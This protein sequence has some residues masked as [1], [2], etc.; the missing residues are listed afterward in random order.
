MKSASTS[1]RKSQKLSD[2]GEDQIISAITRSLSSGE[3]VIVGP[4]DD[5]A[6]VDGGNPREWTL[7]KTDAV[8]ESV[9]FLPGEDPRRVGWKALCRAISDIGAMGGRPDFCLITLSASPETEMAS[10]LALYTGLRKAAKQFGV[11]IVGGELA[12]S[13][14][15]LFCSIALTGSVSRSRCVLR[16]GGRPGDLLYVT[17]RLGGSYHSG[18]HLDFTPRVVEGQW[19]AGEFPLHA[20]MDLSDGLGTD[21]PRLAR[22]S[23]CS[24]AVDLARVPCTKGVSVERALSDGEDFELLFAIAP[25]QKP[26]LEAGWKKRFPRL[27]LTCIGTLQSLLAQP[28]KKGVI[29]RGFD[30]FT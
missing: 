23:Q 11:D 20:M 28:T 9:H 10:L 22:A 8:V 6:V 12:R 29:P 17:G 21:L 25:R 30:H 24:Y 26:M 16:S 27:P 3:K 13:P 18:R 19:L 2:L 5:C 15:P 7:L 1:R 14:G 4:G